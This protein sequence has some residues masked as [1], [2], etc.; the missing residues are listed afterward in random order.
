MLSQAGLSLP[1]NTSNCFLLICLFICWLVVVLISD[2]QLVLVLSCFWNY[3]KMDSSN[4]S[5]GQCG[6][7]F[8]TP[9]SY[10]PDV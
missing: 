2:N 5:A 4:R 7:Q 10:V 6:P 8:V 3:K 9:A 1:K